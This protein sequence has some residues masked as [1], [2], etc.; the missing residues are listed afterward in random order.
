MLYHQTEKG[1]P[2]M[3]PGEGWVKGELLELEDFEELLKI[4]DRIEGYGGPEAAGNEYDRR[5]TEIEAGA[6]TVWA[7]VYWYGREDLGG[8]GNPAVSIPDGDWRRFMEESGAD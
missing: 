3:I 6:G 5:A 2:A 1:Y 8:E 7:W 4:G